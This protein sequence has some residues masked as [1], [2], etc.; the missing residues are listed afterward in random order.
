MRTDRAIRRT[1]ILCRIALKEDVTTEREAIRGAVERLGSV[2][3]EQEVQ[4]FAQSFGESSVE[5]EVT[6]W[7]GSRPVDIRRSR[8]EVVAAVKRALDEAG[9][10]IAIPRRALT[11]DAVQEVDASIE[12]RQTV[13]A[14]NVARLRG[15]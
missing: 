6:W 1:T 7:T 4:V 15:P 12:E 13:R 8:D 11:F 5:F 10:R 2:S 9:I 3:K 14:D